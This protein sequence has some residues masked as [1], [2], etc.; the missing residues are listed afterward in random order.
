M[1][2]RPNTPRKRL[3]QAERVDE[4]MDEGTNQWTNQMDLWDLK[5]AQ[6]NLLK[7]G[8]YHTKEWTTPPT[9]RP[10]RPP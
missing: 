10:P 3:S 6:S 9:A 4:G 2:D 1:P 8:G 5:M 7:S